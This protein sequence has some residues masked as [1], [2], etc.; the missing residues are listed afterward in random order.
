MRIL[1]KKIYRDIK[2]N[3]S[4]FITIFLM[5]FLG[6]FVFSGIH[7]Y[8]DG[9]Q[10]S[11]DK[12]WEEN[13]LQDLWVQGENF[14]KD[15][16]KNIKEI[17]NIKD[18]ERQIT[19]KTNLETDK[20]TTFE[21]IFIE[22]NNISKMYLVE[23]EEFS[24]DKQG[25][26]LDYYYA[27]N[28]D[29]KI[30]DEIVLKYET[31][32]IKEKIL[33]FI[34]TPDHV[35]AIK[36]ENAIFPTHED[37]AYCYLSINEFPVEYIYDEIL[38]DSNIEEFLKGVS[39]IKELLNLG[40]TID[41][42]KQSTKIDEN[43]D[44]QKAVDLSDKIKD[45]TATLYEKVDFIKALNSDFDENNV[46]IFPT[47]IV[48]IDDEG[49][50]A[51]TKANIENKIKAAKAVTDRNSCYSYEGYQSEID[52]GTTYSGVF[53]FL[54]L[55][56]ATLSVVTTMSR[57]VKKQKMQIGTMKALG[58]KKQKIVIHYLN[59]GFYISLLASILGILLGDYILGRFFLNMEMTYFEIPNYN[60]VT[61]P[62]VYI[63]AIAVVALITFVTYLSC[64][65]ILIQSASEALRIEMPK[66]KKSSFSL[67]TKGVFKNTSL[68]TRW[69]LRDLSRNRAR[70]LTAIVGIMGC[71]MLM[72]CA[73]GMWDTMNSYLDWNFGTIN[74]FEYKLS[75]SQNYTDE[76][77]SK[78][79]EKYGASTTESFGIEYKKK[80]SEEK[81]ANSLTVNDSNG[82]LAVTDHDR[83]PM[84][85]GD[86]GVYITEKLSA[87]TGF[88]VGDKITWHI[89]GEDD[90]YETKIIGLNR[91]PQNQQL[92]MTRV[93]YESLGLEYKA[94]SIYTNQDLS[95]VDTI[96]GV[97]TIQDIQNLRSGMESML[98]MM[99]MMVVLLIV[100][101]GI[102]GMVIIYNL[103]V[104]SF[105]EKHYQFATLKV[106][107]FKDK[108]IK[109]IFI[110]Q[111]IWLTIIAIILG[112]P[113]GYY[114]TDFI[115]KEAIGDNYDFN[116][117]IKLYS[118]FIGTVGTLIVS[119]FVNRILA[120][121]VKTI[122]MV[123]SLKGNE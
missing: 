71:T 11:G 57:F 64:R 12:Y 41:M 33:G 16:L 104:L 92:N 5:V 91:D 36:D 85:I 120:K 6:I 65:K 27:R 118:Y 69:N 44:L 29:L 83:K 80:D 37:F 70:T 115:F 48:D 116:A 84:E 55:F 50:I 113:L 23:G 97:E 39:D 81:V 17:D 105:S 24:K 78:L 117:Q 15:D 10:V 52:E 22:S 77:Y 76:Q 67:S 43:I 93:F 122:D 119:V 101:S 112:L 3:K 102:L 42:V 56:I 82:M 94:D 34:E 31:Y 53:T 100:V 62:L 66:V 103:G 58:I 26:W 2:N 89:F 114:M 47:V 98:G 32:T 90:W 49:K 63:L 40:L 54:F 25:M 8:M 61:I 75:L 46:Y 51:E 96:D 109:N 9:M 73:F 13:N 68:S 38:K 4:Q 99:K 108:Q 86:D 14:T 35:Y 107:G 110:Q 28:K 1:N 60:T 20:D 59:Y 95:N 87:T 45:G 21:I 123:T 30:G 79:Q 111:N 74:N 72:V 121:K 19:L 18:A 88:K 7:A 106:L